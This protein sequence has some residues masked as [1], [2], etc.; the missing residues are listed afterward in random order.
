VSADGESQRRERSAEEVIGYERC[1]FANMAKRHLPGAA[2]TQTLTLA[3]FE[4]LQSDVN[5]AFVDAAKHKTKFEPTRDALKSFTLSSESV[6]EG[7]L[8][9]F[10]GF[11][12]VARNQQAESVNCAGE[13]GNDIHISVGNQTTTEW[14]G[15][16][17]EMIPQIPRP[18]G[19]DEK[20]L[21]RLAT[22]PKPEVL[23]I[24]GLTYDNEHMT[25]SNSAHPNGRQPKRVS[26]GDSPNKGIPRM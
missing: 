5:R 12:I 15:V 11:V 3:D 7:A 13:D 14:L 25:N 24:G 23:V 18:T 10:A 2:T 8:V 19:W 6:S 4:A 22:N 1:R 17:A 26:L 9:Q 21:M 16:V 20:T